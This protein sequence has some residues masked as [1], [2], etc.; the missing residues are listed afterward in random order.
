M[1]KTPENSFRVPHLLDLFPDARFLVVGV[2]FNF[3]ALFRAEL[4]EWANDHGLRDCVFFTGQRADITE[5]LSVT[6]IVVSA[7]WHE[8]F[9][10][11]LIEAMAM[12][13]PVVGTN[14]GAAPEIIADGETGLLVPIQDPEALAA[15][16]IDMARDRESAAR[17]GRIGRQRVERNFSIEATVRKASAVFDALAR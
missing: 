1:E 12:A 4:E 8:P 10:R 2:T 16:V 13:R 6:N 7:S 5:I 11:V 3:H 9:G 17:M 14:A 15:A